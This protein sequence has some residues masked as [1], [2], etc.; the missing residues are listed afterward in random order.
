MIWVYVTYYGM[1]LILCVYSI[2]LKKKSDKQ[3]Q[4]VLSKIEDEHSERMELLDN[5]IK[6]YTEALKII[7]ADRAQRTQEMKGTPLH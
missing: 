3:V 1:L 5:L 2:F 7:T 6:D 4:E